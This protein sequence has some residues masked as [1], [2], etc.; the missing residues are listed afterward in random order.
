MDKSKIDF[1]QIASINY[2]RTQPNQDI[3]EPYN[4]DKIL[5]FRDDDY[6]MDKL[7][8]KKNNKLEFEKIFEQTKNKFISLSEK[9][10]QIIN[11]K[12]FSFKEL[13]A[14]NLNI[15]SISRNEQKNDYNMIIDNK[16]SNENTININDN[17]KMNDLLF[18][19]IKDNS[20]NNCNLKMKNHFTI[21][22]NYSKKNILIDNPEETENSK[23]IGNKRKQQ[24]NNIEK[25]GNE[26]K[27][28]FNE[29]LIICKEISKLNDNIIKE[30]Q[31]DNEIDDENIKTTSI[32]YVN[33]M[34]IFYLNKNMI[35][36]L[37]VYNNNKKFLIKENELL[38]QLKI[39]KKKMILILNGLKKI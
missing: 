8:E 26:I 29:I 4:N 13:L 17:K 15:Q 39:I 38:S 23:L 20:N 11:N 35:N 12:G 32:I 9:A 37:Y 7:E 34:A 19:N 2:C 31:N 28:I 6:E 5:L 27:S 14:N 25:K 33:Q 22:N 18:N 1:N 16:N 21:N 10:D 3:D 36:K 30:E 24:N